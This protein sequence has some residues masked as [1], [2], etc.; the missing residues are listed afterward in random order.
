[1][2]EEVRETLRKCDQ[3]GVEERC[4]NDSPPS[5]RTFEMLK[6]TKWNGVDNDRIYAVFDLCPGCQEQ[7]ICSLLWLFLPQDDPS[8]RTRLCLRGNNSVY[9]Q[10]FKI[11]TTREAIF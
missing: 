10:H 7:L 8:G 4:K 5:I 2:V 6:E 11:K 3:C 9:C 1:M